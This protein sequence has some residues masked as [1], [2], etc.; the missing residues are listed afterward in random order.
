MSYLIF[1]RFGMQYTGDEC[2]QWPS[3][4]HTSDEE[5]PEF[6]KPEGVVSLLDTDMY[7]LTMQC[8]ILQ[9]L[10]DVGEYGRMFVLSSLAKIQQRLHTLLRTE[11]PI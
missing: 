7:K 5:I 2:D 11:L 1:D 10:P 8:A 6:E 3:D 4:D 9:F